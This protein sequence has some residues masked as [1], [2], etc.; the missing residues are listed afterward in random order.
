MKNIRKTLLIVLFA[1]IVIPFFF[2]KGQATTLPS[3]YKLTDHITI[4]PKDQGWYNDGYMLCWA[5]SSLNSLETHIQLKSNGD[6]NPYLSV[7]H[8]D[9]LSSSYFE[10][11]TGIVRNI[12][13]VGGSFYALRYFMNNY[14][15][16][17]NNKS[18]LT[19][20]PT[21]NSQG[22]VDT[23]NYISM[24]LRP[25][26]IQELSEYTPE[27]YVH[28]IASFPSIRK[29]NGVGTYVTIDSTYEQI[30]TGNVL[31]E[32]ELTA[33]RDKIKQHIMENGG[34]TCL[35]NP[36]TRRYDSNGIAYLYGATSGGG[37]M[38]TIVGWDDDLDIS[39]KTNGQLN[40]PDKGAYLVLDSY[41]NHYGGNTPNDGLEWVSYYDADVELCNFGYVEVDKTKREISATFSNTNLYNTIKNKMYSEIRNS[42]VAQC[43]YKGI[44]YNLNPEYY[45]VSVNGYTIKMLDLV[46]NTYSITNIDLTN[47]GVTNNDIVELAKIAPDLNDITLNNNE[48]TNI[49]GISNIPK[50]TKLKANNNKIDSIETVKN[51]IN[52]C[53]EVEL[54]N[55]VLSAT[56]ND[57]HICVYPNLFTEAKDSNSKIYSDSGLEFA[58]CTE[59]SDGKGIKVTDVSRVATVTI[60]S[61]NAQGSTLTIHVETTDIKGDVDGNGTINLADALK[62]RRYIANS[63]KWNLT[64]DE[65][66]RA[67]VKEDG[68]INLQD[69]LKLRRY[70]AANSNESIRRKHTDWIW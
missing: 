20:Y 52:E 39:A 2:Y 55:Q 31:T 54:K 38:V 19:K 25:S 48:L 15:P 1:T 59:N 50:L 64:N 7:R 45:P 12:C 8:L 17:S 53:T 30:S 68:T 11:D 14:G 69:T 63:T 5:F 49:N 44:D 36:Y 18:N 61:G 9:Y 13:D 40:P 42:T 35:V 16:V 27:Y 28:K 26:Q 62:L 37:H 70:I 43:A 65:K 51:I 46:A 58:N 67:D 33:N 32:S 66:D 24:A 56:I 47:K 23:N 41:G 57:T 3:S 60:K 29:N 6:E 22:V 21:W 34:V 10:N 4:T